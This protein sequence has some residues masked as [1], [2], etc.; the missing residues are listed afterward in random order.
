[1]KKAIFIVIAVAFM[2]IAVTSTPS[3]ASAKK[4]VR[5][6]VD[7]KPAPAPIDVNSIGYVTYIPN[8]GECVEGSASVT[9]LVT[10]GIPNAKY[11]LTIK[12]V[13][14]TFS[15]DALGEA[16]VVVDVPVAF[17]AEYVTAQ[18]TSGLVSRY[19]G[20]DLYCN[21]AFSPAV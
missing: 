13:M 10:K 12:N 2:A 4:P 9:A 3:I 14:Q 5:P 17:G 1:M 21:G 11:A 6:P 18:L 19:D 7:T 15:T 8:N 20:I 16:T